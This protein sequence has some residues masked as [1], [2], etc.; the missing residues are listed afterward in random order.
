MTITPAELEERILDAFPAGTLAVRALLQVLE[1]VPSTEA[2]TA[3]TECRI[4]PR[5]L[6]NPEFVEAYAATPERLFM[7][8]MHELH[9][10]LLGHTR[11]C[12]QPTALDN[13]VFDAV[14]NATL[15]R[16]FPE[17]GYTSLLTDFYSDE[18]F[19]ECLLRP[20]AGWR[21]DGDPSAWQVPALAVPGLEEVAAVYRQL[22]SPAGATYDDLYSVFRGAVPEAAAA[23]TPLLGSHTPGPDRGAADRALERSLTDA[24]R[25]AA[26]YW[27]ALDPQG[28][29]GRSSIG[30][31]A[32]L[33]V[34][35][36]PTPGNR[37][38]LRSLLLRIAGQ[39]SSAASPIRRLV[40]DPRSVDSA[41]PAFDRRAVV[42]RA[43]GHRP[44]LYRAPLTLPS[45]LP[46]GERVHVY[47]DVSG[48]VSRIIPALYAAVLDCSEFVHPR[49]H[50]FSTQVADVT[51]AQLRRGDCITTGGTD[52]RCVAAHMRDN[53][54]RRAVI[55]TDGFV[56]DPGKELGQTLL[57]AHVGVALTR[58]GFSGDLEPF[59]N[60]LVLLNPT[61]P[62]GRP[63]ILAA[64]PPFSS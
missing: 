46:V 28:P 61:A 3:R 48:S 19:P 10:I 50:L 35:P 18:R 29:K 34:K 27:P 24:V 53:A 40:A 12:A 14:I 2:P 60:C 45:V 25:R 33:V 39:T 49:V 37:A 51:L 20:P 59:A 56:G 38:V 23:G 16:M 52:I 1:V 58:D 62:P 7:L 42:L 22:Y 32:E 36:R 63:A 30:T 17:P 43:L 11:R 41:I 54:V 26:K 8:V 21:H 4:R 9:H 15:C 55:I 6:I 57:R 47:L 31:M 13:L 44:L 5:M 64:A